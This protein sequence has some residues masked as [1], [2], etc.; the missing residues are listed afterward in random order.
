[1]A[2]TSNKGNIVHLRTQMRANPRFRFEL[3]AAI[4]RTARDNGVELDGDTLANLVLVDA[5]EVEKALSTPNLPGGT[6]C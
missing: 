1:M 5:S 6:N 2:S 3:M 4:S